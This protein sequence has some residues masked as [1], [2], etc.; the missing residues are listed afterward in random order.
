MRW[1][2]HGFQIE[3]TDDGSPTLR[4]EGESMHHSGGALSE[5]LLIY[6]SPLKELFAQLEKP[7][8]F[9]LGLGLGY[10]ELVTAKLALEAGKPFELETRESEEILVQTFMDWLNGDQESFEA[11]VYHGILASLC[12]LDGP[13]GTDVRAALRLALE[14][15]R[16]HVRGRLGPGEEPPQGR[17]HGFMYDAFSSKTTP[18]LWSE[19]ALRGIMRDH[20]QEDCLFSTYACTG[21]LKRS[22]KA[23]GFE[24]DLREGFRGKRYS[25]LGRRGIFQG[26][27]PGLAITPQEGHSPAHAGDPVSSD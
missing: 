15:G 22:L 24:L 11:G 26:Q 8:V 10:V 16:W 19:E 5:T 17:F 9:S 4:G 25:T 3:Q 20:A 7:R 1:Q 23:E 2:S 14:E 21:N 6:G 13:S 18:L 27:A 12:A